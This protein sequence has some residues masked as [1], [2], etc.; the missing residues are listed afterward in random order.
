MPPGQ[1]PSTPVATGPGC[2][3]AGGG[4][5]GPQD[6]QPSHGSLR[7]AGEAGTG[8]RRQ[9]EPEIQGEA[10][11]SQA[12][13]PDTGRAG[14]AA[15]PAWEKHNSHARQQLHFQVNWIRS[16][17][18]V[19]LLTP[20]KSLLA[21]AVAVPSDAGPPGADPLEATRILGR[22]PQKSRPTCYDT[23][24]GAHQNSHQN[25]GDR[26]IQHSRVRTHRNWAQTTKILGLEPCG[27]PLFVLLPFTEVT[28]VRKIQSSP[29]TIHSEQTLRGSSLT[30]TF[31]TCLVP[32]QSLRVST[33]P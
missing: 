17:P 16:C 21:R 27:I 13:Q 24:G 19:L 25:S 14:G 26:R 3:R 9:Q 15:L 12:L 20:A 5:V 18:G 1:N 23:G 28:H 29:P 8:G 2:T 11:E 4:E 6:P 10:E 33:V 30:L 31:L 32:S 7:P 22:A